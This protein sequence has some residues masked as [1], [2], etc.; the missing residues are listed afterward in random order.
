MLPL[1]RQKR[2]WLKWV[3]L[4]VILALGLTT[5]LLFVDTPQGLAP[6]VGAREV[7]V[8]A[9]HP[10]TAA[11]YGRYYRRLVETYQQA[12]QLDESN[13]QMLRQLGLEQ[14]ALNQLISRYAVIHAAGEMGVGVS[15][16][17]LV[18]AISRLFQDQGSFVGADRYKQILQ[19]NSMT[20]KEFEAAMQRDLVGDKLRSILT[21]G[22]LATSA[23]A[24]QQ[25]VERNEQVKIQYA[26]FDP[27]VLG[28]EGVTDEA[29]QEFFAENQEDFRIDE[30]RR[31]TVLPIV[32]SPITVEVS[33][34]LIAAELANVPG[35]E[36][37]RARHILIR[38]NDDEVTARAQAETILT[39]V[40]A[41]GSFETLAATFSEDTATALR[42]GDLGYFGRGQMVP[43][44]E[45]AAFGMEPGQTSDLV[46]TPFGF[47]IIQTL[48]KILDSAEESKRPY[49]E[50]FAPRKEAER[51]TAELAEQLNAEVT[52][53]KTL[54][55]VAEEHSLELAMTEPIQKSAPGSVKF[56][57]GRD[58]VE[59]AFGVEVGQTIG[60]FSTAGRAFIARLEDVQPT[61]IPELAQVKSEVRTRF[62][63]ERGETLAQEK[64]FE[65]FEKAER[66]NSLSEVAREY[67]VAIE[68]TDF[69]KRGAMI[70]P[71]LAY[72][73]TVGEQAFLL[74][75]NQISTPISVSGK[76][77]IIQVLEKSG[78]D[79]AEFESQK[80]QLVEQ[81]TLQKR[82]D[83]YRAYVD[84][85]VAELRRDELIVINQQ[86]LDQL[87]GGSIG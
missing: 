83:F 37:V 63:S 6:G 16:P 40:R 1:F 33:P 69:F 78:I 20:P 70:N 51:K 50:F 28:R 81:L 60:P 15:N 4:L 72:A 48:D 57:L 75:I 47:H 42:G 67:K 54:E 35:G 5:V 43:E 82:S 19:S 3:L 38:F 12:Y 66:Q 45:A 74:D 23:E 73:P 22:I 55:Q 62:E 71:E 2:E 58:F 59:A 21:D 8:V 17:E 34:E 80:E 56:G 18:E 46:R 76:Y 64:A 44:F 9:G 30:T 11:E 10:I 27:E 32:V 61:Y 31:L 77:V 7:A 85:V 79:E 86:L 41:G 68:T 39:Q 53:G 26:L 87:S 84:N 52:A 14:Q 65:F 25:F 13:S 49:A 29:L 36:Q 24:R